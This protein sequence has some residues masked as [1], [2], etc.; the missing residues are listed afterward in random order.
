MKR[1]HNCSAR[2]PD[3]PPALPG[4]LLAATLAATL[5]L[6]LPAA[7]A[8]G[9]ALT[10]LDCPDFQKLCVQADRTGNLDLKQ[11]VAQLEGNVRGYLRAQDST[12]FGERLKA[13]RNLQ[14][15]WDR[16]EL[17]SGVRL[18]EPER[19]ISAD[20]GVFEHNLV[21]L[22][23]NVKVSDQAT[24]MES[25][26]AVLDRT[27]HRTT[28]RGTP[29]QPVLLLISD[30]P[31]PAPAQS[32]GAAADAG[33]PP[34]AL[35]GALPSRP[36]GDATRVLAQK[37]VVEEQS[38]QVVLTGQVKVD[39]TDRQINLEAE[40]VTLVFNEDKTLAGFQARGN[41]VIV[42]PGRRLTA[43]AARSQNKMQTILLLGKAHLQQAG[44]FDLNSDRL[45]V[46]T[47]TTKG[48]VRSED[49]QKPINLSL[50]ISAPKPWRLERASSTGL[51]ERG[52]PPAVVQ[53]L[54]P[55]VGRTFTSQDTFQQAVNDRLTPEES[56]R[57]LPTI[58]SQAH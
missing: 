5:S 3:A 15:D 29:L 28:L 55:L 1:L 35:P 38:H 51:G 23:G 37:A 11:G 39:M 12:F 56:E 41:V 10:P 24:W 54:E 6:T 16:L 32:L 36:I 21:Q 34:G 57:Y 19:R 43:D 49:R 47:D 31:R 13:F 46:F 7:P 14:N 30:T 9:V 4:L 40:T 48:M 22:V 42:Q 44:Q 52:V 53:K 45:E 8:A 18:L 2:P 17:D 33:T 25:L 27:S 58:L 20:H 26:E 50:E